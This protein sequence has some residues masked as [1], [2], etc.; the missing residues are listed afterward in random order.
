MLFHVFYIYISTLLI[1]IFFKVLG[2]RFLAC[3][4][5]VP[6]PRIQPAPPALEAWSLNHWTATEVPKLS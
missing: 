6:P 3:E 2:P 4:I 5:L 1:V